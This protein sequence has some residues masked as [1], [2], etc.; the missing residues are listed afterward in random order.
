MIRTSVSVEARE[1]GSRLTRRR[2]A[3]LRLA[4]AVAARATAADRT[5][6]VEIRRLFAPGRLGLLCLRRLVRPIL[7]VRLIATALRAKTQRA[8]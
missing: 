2:G 6:L 3:S 4:V 1:P 7:V 8:T 5:L